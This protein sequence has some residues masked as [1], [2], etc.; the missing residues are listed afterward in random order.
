MTNEGAQG[1]PEIPDP[2]W[3]LD[4]YGPNAAV[5][6]GGTVLTLG[7]AFQAERMFCPAE[8]DPANPGP[9]QAQR[10]RW[11]A[12]ALAAGGSLE[13]KDSWLTEEK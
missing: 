2:Q 4:K 7:G 5:Q 10:T 3:L 11:L 13:P 12:G 9:F 1:M 6:I 8:P